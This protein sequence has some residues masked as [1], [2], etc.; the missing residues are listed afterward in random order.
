MGYT[1]FQAIDEITTI[2]FDNIFNIDEIQRLQNL[3][4]DA[5]GVSSIITHPDGIPIT[6]PSNFCRLC[7]HLVRK[8]EIGLANCNK[9]S[10]L[11][12]EL[13]DTGP[14]LITC[15]D[16]GLL[17]AGVRITVGGKHIANWIIGQVRNEFI[18]NEVLFQYAEIIGINKET[19]KEAWLE[20][21]IISANQ[22]QKVADMLFVYANEIAEKAYK[23]LEFEKQLAIHEKAKTLLQE[24]E[25]FL[26][27]TQSI[28]NLGTY[29][30]NVNTG[31]WE[32]S[33]LLDTIFGIPK[34]FDKSVGGWTT[35]I[36]PEWQEIMHNYF[37]NDVIR[38]KCKFDKEYK[39]IRQNDH[40]VRWVHGIGL[41][42]YDENNVPVYMLGT[43]RDITERKQNELI[44]KEKN[45][46]IEAK[47]A[48]YKRLN[49][50]L[51]QTNIELK[52]AK[53]HAEESDRL[54]TA[55]LQNLSHE[56]RTPMNAIMGFS[57]LL[58]DQYNNK[59]KLEKYANIINQ[60]SIDLLDII[61]DILDI[62]K[63]ESGQ[64]A[65]YL[66]ECN[67]NELFE[68][69]RLF[70]TEY[71]KRTNKE[72]I[73]FKVHCMCNKDQNYVLTDKVKL[74][75]IFINLISN[76]FKFTSSGLIEGGWKLDEFGN[77]IFYVSDTGIGIPADKQSVIFD[78]FT[79][80]HFGINNNAGGNGLGLSI[81]KGLVE[82]MGGK[83]FLDS[84]P[85]KGSTFTFSF[86]CKLLSLE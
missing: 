38:N 68:E 21:P 31:I 60:R 33:E 66:E 12:G 10:E 56:I 57:T 81:V 69:L 19:Y 71:Q 50:E 83:I 82:L 51:C 25:Y 2:Q 63:I 54:K 55:F 47:S 44:L 1:E 64:L 29:I 20:V 15:P 26:K 65:V 32:S 17:K 86:P 80:L 4:S 70:F 67:L 39:I 16:T 79:Q 49:E 27:E 45:A 36:H 5:T 77:I 37:V 18:D 22:F 34:D 9:I 41:L 46:E 8:T 85:E 6:N 78:R 11:L 13:N 74:K 76:A 7:E 42:N 40:E 24:N 75:Q 84:E 3:F 35:I 30:L 28:A 23:F 58:V 52:F 62:A 59:S 53:E 61:N 72:H 73:T 43:I 48:E 14:K